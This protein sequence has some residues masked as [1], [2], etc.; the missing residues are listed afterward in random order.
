LYLFGGSNAQGELLNDLHVFDT[1]SGEWSLVEA[2]GTAPR[3]REMASSVVIEDRIVII[4]GRGEHGPLGCTA[5]L[6]TNSME[7]VEHQI[8]SIDARMAQAAA[9][10][11][12][13]VFVFGG[14][15]GSG[16]TDQLLCLNAESQ[17]WSQVSCPHGSLPSA[18][19]AHT[20][21]RVGNGLIVVGGLDPEKDM[22]DAYVLELTTV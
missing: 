9:A 16:I 2:G 19:F 14:A 1:S 3:P 6:D 10:M 7:W 5:I 12:T 15:S 21:T 8:P 20:F 18:R 11:G 22:N 4:G 17:E 13:S